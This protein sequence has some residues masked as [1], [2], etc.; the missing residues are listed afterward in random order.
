M[1]AI[2]EYNVFA[3]EMAHPR[4]QQDDL[5][6]FHDPYMIDLQPHKDAVHEARI[7]REAQQAERRRERTRERAGEQQGQI[8]RMI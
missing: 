3:G 6:E 8:I 7:Q 5:R 1:T 4:D 2:E